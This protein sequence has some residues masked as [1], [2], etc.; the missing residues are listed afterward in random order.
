MK[1]AFKSAGRLGNK[2]LAVLAGCLLAALFASSAQATIGTYVSPATVNAPPGIPPQVD[3]TNFVNNG[4]WNI[5]TF[6]SGFS[7]PATPYQTANTLNY[8]NTGTMN[9]SIG[10]E[11]DYGPIGSISGR[12]WSA[13]FFNGNGATIYGQDGPVE[14]TPGVAYTVAYLLVSATNIVNQGTLVADPYGEM[15]LSGSGVNL[16]RSGLE[17]VPISG[18][19]GVNTSPT[20]FTPDTAVYDQYWMGGTN[21]PHAFLPSIWN[22]ATVGSMNFNNV[23]QSGFETGF[24][25]GAVVSGS[26]GSIFPSAADSYIANVH[27]FILITTNQDLV[28]TNMYLAYSNIVKQAI[29]VQVGD[30]NITP[31]VR[32]GPQVSPTNYFLPMAAQLLSYSTNLVTD[33]LQ[34]STIYVEDNLAAV[35][36]N[37]FLKVSTTVNL[38]SPCPIPTFRPDSA[39]VTRADIPPYYYLNGT[40][41]LGVPPSDF[42]YFAGTETNLAPPYLPYTDT[43]SNQVA[44]GRADYYGALIDNLASEAPAGYA[45][46]NAPGKIKIYAQNLN[47]VKTRISSATE[48]DV[49]ATNLVGSGGAIMDC[50]NLS[51]NLGSTNGSL[52]FVNLSLPIVDRVRGTVTE[53][54]GLWTNYLISIY[55]NF[56]T[57]SASSNGPIYLESDI[58]N[59]VEV[60]MAITVVDASGLAT[61]LPVTVQNLILHSPNM[62]VSDTVT[63]TNSMLFDGTS[64]TITN[65]GGITTSTGSGVS[66]WTTANAPKLLYFTNDGSLTI[67][68]DAHFGDDTTNH[69]VSFANYGTIN[70][71]NEYVNS[72][73]FQG[74]G[75]QTVSAG[76]FLTTSTGKVEN[77]SISA[78]NNVQFAATTL[79]LNQATISS[80]DELYFYVTGSLFDAGWTSG[81]QLFCNN[82]FDLAVKPATGDLLGTAL[83]TTT[84]V[85]ANVDH[86]W[87]GIDKGNSSAG[88]TNNEAVGQLILNEGSD[89]E[90]SFHATGSTNAIYVDLLDLSHCPDFQDP[91]VLTIEPNFTIYY[92]AAKL[93]PTFT[94]PP[95]TNGIPQEPEEFL[96]GLFGGRLV[97][98]SSFAGPNSSVYVVETNN[99]Q[100]V[101]VLVNKALRYS[102]IIDSNGNGIPNYYDPYPF[103]LPSSLI[104]SGAMVQSNTPPVK[105]FA[106]S[107]TAVPNTVYQVQSSPSF[108]SASWTPLLNYTNT[109]STNVV[110]TVWDTNAVAGQR[111]YR[112]SHP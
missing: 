8:T 110:V 30:P 61:T 32:F 105:K 111:F 99:N 43:Y 79:K 47:L 19:G 2:L 87:S 72:A 36:T 44:S 58:T 42:Y 46:T 37:G 54:S 80:G 27:P 26:T 104:L 17:I 13:N 101:S 25:C 77:G 65:G 10:W 81:N 57:N 15:V 52:N 12:G 49:A 23:F 11:F 102:K 16:S 40:T 31:S 82:G 3:A 62:T 35:G 66:S 78:G 76:Y 86:Y 94:V 21:G 20:N 45:Q 22:G 29:F 90:F 56:I 92:A 67:P 51:Y 109:A 98:V 107:W 50:Q 7:Y 18:N 5:E 4:V 64:L 53:W 71:G 93:P 84:P 38:A 39:T 63:V 69:Y 24:P 88:Y 95:N 41:G 106:I 60:D 108:V 73:T 89:S 83:E 75:S 85:F 28:T 112:V 100:V 55:P 14:V 33:A 96:N 70:T 34:P 97:W 91:T 9:S 1:L 59:V 6:V 68:I 103:T 74:S 48:I